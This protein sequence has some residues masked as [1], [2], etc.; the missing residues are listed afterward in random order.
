M[1]K[2][3][4]DL[5]RV[6]E[7]LTRHAANDLEGVIALF[8][9]GATVEDPVGSEIHAGLSA[10]RAFYAKTHASNGRMS[11]ERIGPIL[12]GG[13]EVALHVRAGLDKPGSPKPMDVIY[14]IRFG[15]TGGISSL[16]VWF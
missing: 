11:I 7:Y 14:T 2:S 13:N 12:V 16:R 1:S 3:A 8:E 5:A 15:A 9:E 10:V 4:V 6:D